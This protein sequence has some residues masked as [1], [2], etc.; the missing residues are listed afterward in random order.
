MVFT[1]ILNKQP[2]FT[3]IWPFY[4]LKPDFTFDHRFRTAMK[5]YV[6]NRYSKSKID[7]FFT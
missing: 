3:P 6:Q 2:H 1:A 7:P 5:N 4:R